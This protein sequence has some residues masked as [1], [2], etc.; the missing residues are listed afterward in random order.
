MTATVDLI[1]VRHHGLIEV[2]HHDIPEAT[3]ESAESAKKKEKDST[4]LAQI[5]GPL[6]MNSIT[7]RTLGASL[8]VNGEGGGVGTATETVAMVD[9]GAIN[10]IGVIGEVA[11]GRRREA[12]LRSLKRKLKSLS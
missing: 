12:R 4:G 5:L 11:R 9:G 3:T 1:E 7:A 8:V 6:E 10:A 2:R